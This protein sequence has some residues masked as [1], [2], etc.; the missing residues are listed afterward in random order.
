LSAGCGL[1]SDRSRSRYRALSHARTRLTDDDHGSVPRGAPFASA[2]FLRG[3]AADR[4]T[5][6]DSWGRSASEVVPPRQSAGRPDDPA[7]GEPDSGETDKTWR[8]PRGRRS[9]QQVWMR[10]H[11]T[12]V[13]GEV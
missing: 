7:T 3:R 13:I 12:R 6:A 1:R 11:C 4:R 9:G 8:I 2:M 10:T 5:V